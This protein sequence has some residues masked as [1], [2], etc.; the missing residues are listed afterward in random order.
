MTIND[1]ASLDLTKGMTL[2][3]WVNPAALGTTWRT[4]AIKEASGAMSYALYANT[5][6]TRPSGHVVYRVANSTPVARRR[7]R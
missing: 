1:S 3:A 7:S 6:T 4:V 5:D 2:E